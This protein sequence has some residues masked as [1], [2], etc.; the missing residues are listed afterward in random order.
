MKQATNKFQVNFVQAKGRKGHSK[1]VTK[2]K[3]FCISSEDDKQLAHDTLPSNSQSSTYDSTINEH[4]NYD[5]EGHDI[6]DVDVAGQPTSYERCQEKLADHWGELRANLLHSKIT[7]YGHPPNGVTCVSCS[8]ANAAVTCFDC[9][10]NV[11][12]CNVCAVKCHANVNVMHCLFLWKVNIQH[13]YII[14]KLI[15]ISK[16]Y[17]K[18]LCQVSPTIHYNISET[19]VST[20]I[21]VQCIS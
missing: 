16:L 8:D 3:S 7:A 1:I 14:P 12:Y 20:M 10:P 2:R 5:S 15:A 4:P 9:G 17:K 6:S 13:K 18:Q 19:H 11:F 21:F